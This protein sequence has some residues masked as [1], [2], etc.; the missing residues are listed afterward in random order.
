L[1]IMESSGKVCVGFQ[2]LQMRPR[3]GL[4]IDIK[5]LS[6]G[7]YFAVIRVGQRKRIMKFIKAE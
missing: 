4:R 7:M 5:S 3:E 2:R 1:D 6:T